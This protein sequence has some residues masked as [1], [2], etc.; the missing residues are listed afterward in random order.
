[1]TILDL[2]ALIAIDVHVQPYPPVVPQ[3]AADYRAQRMA[4]VIFTVDAEA[5]TG[6]RALSNE[7]I[8]EAADA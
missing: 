2:G 8:A 4:A 1:M 5:A 3:I 6:Q 7:E